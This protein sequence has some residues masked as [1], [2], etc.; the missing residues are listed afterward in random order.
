MKRLLFLIVTILFTAIGQ[1]RIEYSVSFENILHHEAEITVTFPNL[2]AGT[3]EARMGRSSPGRYA[4][5]EFAKNVYNVR[6]VD[7]KGKQ[8]TITRPNLHQWDVAGHDGT[9]VI[10]YTLFADHPDGTYAG[11]DVSHAHLNIPATFLWA[12]GLHE[13]PIQ[14][15]LKLP[16]D[17][18]WKVATQLART[19][20]PLTFTAPHLQ[21]FMD[22]PIEISD[23]ALRAW[24]IDSGGKTYTIKLAA[25]HDATDPYIDA[26]FE[27]A[28]P[29]ILEQMAVFGELPSY[30][31]GEYVFL[32][33][34][35]PW[36]GGDGMEHRNSTVISGAASLKPNPFNLLGVLSHEYF[37]SWN[38]ERIRP[39]SLEPFNFEEANMSGE[40]WFAEGFS[41]YYG[42]LAI[43]RAQ[44]VSLDRFTRNIRSAVNTVINAPGRAF[45]NVA[46]MSRQAPFVDAATAVDRNNR[47]NTFI[48]YYT[49]GEAIGLGLDLSIRSKFPGLSLDD[50]MRGMWQK[51]GKPEK[52]YTN[53][54]IR[55]V[56]GEVT[57]DQRFA[58]EFFEKYIYGKEAVDYQSLLGNA[59]L[60]LRKARAGK[61]TLGPVFLNYDGGKATIATATILNSPLYRAGLDRGDKILKIGSTAITS[62]Q[63][64]DSLVSDAKPGEKIA[65]EYE[66]RA[67]KKSGT[68]TF[69]EDSTLEIVP[70]EHASM[71]VTDAMEAFRASWLGR[72]STHQL[73]ELNKTCPT[74]RRTF[75][76]ANEFCPHDG[77]ELKTVLEK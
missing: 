5:H 43:A 31:F 76:F 39:K 67:A 77:S 12:R 53:E 57:G 74:C 4:L 50:L 1:E 23:H 72:K 58:N 36:A 15:S 34:F 46:D 66:Q 52:P 68:L 59:G 49:W 42:T 70:Y 13:R 71:P 17:S 60:L 26:Y 47:S 55:I 2:P 29:V 48:S 3:L 35:Q 18:K 24:K 16:K 51:F 69:D 9:V 32:A 11:V 73:P 30:D 61:A 28:K 10:S 75:P 25:H 41:N 7:G 8:L 19:K 37:H 44:L 63:E 33:D 14:V 27:M 40:L 22:S 56:L 54:D 20:D 6:A 62:K 65:I 45:F 21:Y 38:V 64:W